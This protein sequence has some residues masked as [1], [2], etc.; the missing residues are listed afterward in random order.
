MT[1]KA[2]EA[3]RKAQSHT[4][5]IVEASKCQ[6]A[7]IIRSSSSKK[8]RKENKQTSVIVPPTGKRKKGLLTPNVSFNFEVPTEEPFIR[9]HEDP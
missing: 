5:D 6:L 3:T 4:M 9:Q 8:E 2:Q 1:L 7:N